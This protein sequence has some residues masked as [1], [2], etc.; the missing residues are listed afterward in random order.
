MGEREILLVYDDHCPAC[1]NYCR[2]V[3][4]RESV[5]VLQ[6]INAREPSAVMDEV[7]ALGWDIDQGMVLKVGERLFYGADAIHA[8]ALMSSPSGVFNRLNHWFFR[9]SGRAAIFY[10]LL[11]SSR[12]ILLNVLRVTKINNLKIQGND[13]F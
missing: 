13:R 11:R 10:P 6:L 5:G 2:M 3:R 4:I 8:L 7:T 9:S 12:N 1:D